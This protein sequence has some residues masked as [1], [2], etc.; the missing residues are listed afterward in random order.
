[1]NAEGT[2]NVLGLEGNM[3]PSWIIAELEKKRRKSQR[4]L[5]DRPRLEVD[6]PASPSWS[7]PPEK[8]RAPIVI[9]F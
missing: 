9:E 6:V 5:D 8:R 1:L 7:P 4:G 2:T 3:L